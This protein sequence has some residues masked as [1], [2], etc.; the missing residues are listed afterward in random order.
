[1]CGG[2]APHTTFP[3]WGCI[4]LGIL[5]AVGSH[6]RVTWSYWHFRESQRKDGTVAQQEMEAFGGG[7]GEGGRRNRVGLGVEGRERLK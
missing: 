6:E 2:H 7:S 4:V 3:G 1:M 5:K